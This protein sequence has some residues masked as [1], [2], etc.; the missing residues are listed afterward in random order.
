MRDDVAH[1]KAIRW[2]RNDG[3]NKHSLRE[4]TDSAGVGVF[5]A[6]AGGALL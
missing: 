5:F 4:E 6:E 3:S 2:H 1:D